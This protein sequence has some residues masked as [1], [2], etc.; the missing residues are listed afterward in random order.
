MS[1]LIEAITRSTALSAVALV[2][3]AI[4]GLAVGRIIVGLLRVLLHAYVLPGISLKRFGAG[5]GAWA[6]VTG[7]TD[8]IGREFAVQLAQKQFNVV[9][10]SRTQDKLDKLAAEIEAAS[11]VQTRV[12]QLDFVQPQHE[13]YAKIA[14][15]ADELELNVLVNN[16]GMNSEFPTPF[17]EESEQMLLNTVQVNTI[18]AVKITRSLVPGMISRCVS[19]SVGGECV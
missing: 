10:V 2:F 13:G 18:G 17:N 6:L 16:V 19:C 4:G 8:G 9:L 5:T 1:H 15:L 11:G 7:C 12:V 3:A 14:A